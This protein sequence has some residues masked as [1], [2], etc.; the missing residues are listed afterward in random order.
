MYAL[1]IQGGDKHPV[2]LKKIAEFET[3]SLKYLEQ[4]FSILKKNNIVD[5]L[6][7]TNG[8]YILA[9]PA[10]EI[11]IKDIIYAMDGPVQPVDCLDKHDCVKFT[12]CSVNWLWDGLKVIVDDYLGNISLEDMRKKPAGGIYANI[13]R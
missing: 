6:R 4:I 13:S 7:G 5:S 8:G 3:I 10:T 2:S 1:L 9:K 11:K 12:E